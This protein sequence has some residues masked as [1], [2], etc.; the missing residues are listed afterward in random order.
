MTTLTTLSLM[1]PVC[2]KQFRS[3]SIQSTNSFRG[4][5][6]DFHVHAW[7][8]QPL[9]YLIHTCCICGYSGTERSFTDSEEISPILR[10]R[11]WNELTPFFTYGPLL[12]SEKF[13]AAAKIALWREESPRYIADLLIRAAWCCVSEG[14]PEAE[15]FFRRKAAWKFEEALSGFDDIEKDE[16]AVITYLIGELW[17]RIGDIQQAKIWFDKVPDEITDIET[18]QWIMYA[19]EMQRDNPREWFS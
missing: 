2:E 1:C 13:E 12:G 18:Q 6:T 5:R 14:D 15:R 10:M 17:R 19:A 16:R 11:V 4:K 8:T 7:G 9:P 3:Q